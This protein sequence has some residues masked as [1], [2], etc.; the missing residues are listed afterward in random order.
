[1][2]DRVN[3]QPPARAV[4]NKPESASPEKAPSTGSDKLS[5]QQLLDQAQRR[6]LVISAHAR[7]RL[8]RRNI[9]IEE[10]DLH[11]ITEAMDRA[12][13]KGARSSLLL[14]GDIALLASVSNRTIIT[15]VDGAEQQEQ[16]FTGIDSAVILK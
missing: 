14:F 15:A 4:V 12:G 2:V 6:P 16:I 5:F 9:R 11:R 3:F 10:A 13:A 8:E 1:M 7:E